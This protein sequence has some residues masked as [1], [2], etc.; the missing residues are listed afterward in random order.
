[1]SR[2]ISIAILLEWLIPKNLTH[3]QENKTCSQE[4]LDR[5]VMDK[6]FCKYIIDSFTPGFHNQHVCRELKRMLQDL[7]IETN[8]QESHP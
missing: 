4:M 3:F 8:L 7:D 6:T 5:S 2:S 1:M